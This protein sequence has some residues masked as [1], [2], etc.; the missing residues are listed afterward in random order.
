MKE[1]LTLNNFK[2]DYAKLVIS[3]PNTAIRMEAAEKLI[4]RYYLS[5]RTECIDWV[6][7][8]HGLKLFA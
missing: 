3:H 2:Q 5:I 8:E 7:K 6:K 4:S 1:E